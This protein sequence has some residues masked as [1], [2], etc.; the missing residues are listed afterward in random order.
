MVERDT[1]DRVAEIMDETME[2][3]N[4][5]GV[6]HKLNY[7]D[8]EIENSAPYD[9]AFAR[10]EVTQMLEELQVIP[11]KAMILEPYDG[12]PNIEYRV[13][14]SNIREEERKVTREVLTIE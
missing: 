8:V 10:G 2:D 1:M 9:S 4:V 12:D 14:F 7:I 6:K 11:I 5:L 3:R 13:W